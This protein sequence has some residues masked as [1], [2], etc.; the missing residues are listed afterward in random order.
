MTQ[1]LACAN[2]VHHN[3]ASEGGGFWLDVEPWGMTVEAHLS[4][5]QIFENTPWTPAAVP[6]APA[7]LEGAGAWM[8]I[9]DSNAIL[10]LGTEI[11]H[12]TFAWNNLDAAPPTCAISCLSPARQCPR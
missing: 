6:P 10:P 12:N 5:N 4:F 8:N 2:T 9:L 1:L 11:H 7:S 3:D